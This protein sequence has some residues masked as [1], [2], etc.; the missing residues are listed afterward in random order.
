LINIPTSHAVDVPN[1]CLSNASGKYQKKLGDLAGLY[2]DQDAFETLCRERGDCVV[3]DVTDHRTTESRGDLIFGV[4][5]M[6]PGQIG[7]EYYLTRGHI[8]ARANRP[9]TYRGEAGHGLMLMESPEGETRIIEVHPHTICYVPPFW[10]HRSINVGQTDLVMSFCYPSDAGQDYSVIAKTGGM[11]TR[12]VANG[13]EWQAIPNTRYR[14]RS[15]A[16]IQAIYDTA[17]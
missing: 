14:P 15:A 4:T 10:I 9:E 1:G 3:Y 5:R 8:H 17:D 13:I 16:D 11:K 2:L 12:I 7:T 6:S